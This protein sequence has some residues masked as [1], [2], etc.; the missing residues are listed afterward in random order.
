ML[1]TRA[2]ATA[3][4]N[5]K[6]MELYTDSRVNTLRQLDAKALTTRVG[7]ARDARDRARDLVQR[8]KLASRDR[9]GAKRGASGMANERSKE[10]ATLLGDILSRFE[11][12]LRQVEREERKSA[13][14]AERAANA[15]SA[16]KSVSKQSESSAPAKSA[17]G[18]RS[19][20]SG[21]SASATP[22]KSAVKTAAGSD[23]KTA[24]ASSKSAEQA[25]GSGT[26]AKSAASTAGS[27][28][29]ESSE[30]AT[31]KARPAKKALTPEQAL[32]RTR[33][34]LEAKQGQ[35]R[36]PKSWETLGGTGAEVGSPG[37]QNEEAARRAEQLHEGEARIPAI[38]GSN[39]TR[40]RINQGKRAARRS[41]ATGD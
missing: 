33:E 5:Q 26:K 2:K 36:Q 10:K 34:L 18:R 41:P 23:A 6:E 38:Q 31:K 29:S 9:T 15:G 27:S 3:L 35:A 24:R 4:L 17:G 16:R 20:A 12:Q 28:T 30:G 37:Y 25:K 21:D 19:A 40:D 8:Q 11:A 39:S 22:R 7:R 14:A 13:K 1:I 32:E